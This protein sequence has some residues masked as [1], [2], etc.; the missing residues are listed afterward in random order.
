M[1]SKARLKQHRIDAACGYAAGAYLGVCLCWI[2][3]L[4]IPGMSMLFLLI[5]TCAGLFGLLRTAVLPARFKLIPAVTLGY[6][7]IVLII[8]LSSP[9]RHIALTAVVGLGFFYSAAL[10]TPMF[11]LWTRDFA[12]PLPPWVCHH[13]D[14]PLYGLAEP[15]CPE[16]GK[17]FDPSRVPEP[18]ESALRQGGV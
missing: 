11:R 2:V 16:C 3:M 17:P 4:F 7:L 5:A 1:L 9:P 6:V 18:P 12:K 10:L 8:M 13:C 15:F 14:Y